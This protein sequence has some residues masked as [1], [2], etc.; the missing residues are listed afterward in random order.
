MVIPN[1]KFID[2]KIY[3]SNILSSTIIFL[4][5]KVTVELTTV[6]KIAPAGANASD[7]F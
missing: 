5:G 6:V 2:G 1:S 7:A 4:R 3:I